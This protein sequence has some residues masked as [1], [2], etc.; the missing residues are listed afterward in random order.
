MAVAP[1]LSDSGRQDRILFDGSTWT[2]ADNFSLI[3]N[4]H[5]IKVGFEIRD[6][7]TKR[8]IE[9]NPFV[10]YNSLDDL[11]VDKPDRVQVSFGVPDGHFGNQNYGFYVQDDWRLSKRFQLNLGLRYEYYSRL[12]GPWNIV[13]D[14]FG[15]FAPEGT[16]IF[17]ADR[18]N[19]A[20]R[21]GLVF[22]LFGTGKTILR[23]GGLV[24]YGPPQPFFYY[25]MSFLPGQLPFLSFFTAADLPASVPLK[26]PFPLDFQDKVIE[27]VNLLPKDLKI[28][29]SVAGRH[30]RDEYTGQ[31]NLSL[32][33]AITNSLAVQG[34][35]VGSRGLKL[36]AGG[37]QLNPLVPATGQR[38]RPDLGDIVYREHDARSSY[39]AMQLSLNQRSNKGLTIDTYYTFSKTLQYGNADGSF[40]AD[41]S[42]QDFNNIGESYGPKQSDTAHRFVLVPSYELPTPGFAKQSSPGHALLGGWSIQG[43]VN[44]RS[45]YPIDINTGRD[46]IGNGRSAGQRPDLVPGVEPRVKESDPLLWLTRAAFDTIATA[47]DKRFGNLGYNALRGPSAFWMD[48]ALHKSFSLSERQRLQFR[49]EVFNLLN[50][51]VLG[52][53]VTNLAN[54][55]FGRVISGS[56]GRS[57]QF[58]LKYLF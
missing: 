14:P 52:Q 29:R 49:L 36:F 17:D 37:R 16:P 51:M 30:R 19:F 4:R 1:G 35:Y 44:A 43:I 11:I 45:G 24:T 3:R 13:D 47:R 26:W 46:V 32:Q 8:I 20:P 7:N 28:G 56:D 34:S 58:A 18:N 6:V 27:N 31:W 57:L 21:L 25:D 23:A 41:N 48:A 54:V 9:Q 10:F 38:L 39:H 40:V 55:N 15:A 5:T 50:H 22:D 42:T 2:V 33:H 12:V 53:P